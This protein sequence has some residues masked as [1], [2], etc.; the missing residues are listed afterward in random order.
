MSLSQST[1]VKLH[2]QLLGSPSGSPRAS[3]DPTV[4]FLHGLVMD[5][6][7]S[8]FFTMANTVSRS[9]RVLLYDLRGHGLSERPREGYG[10]DAHV[11]DLKALLDE[12]QGELKG[13]LEIAGP[14]ILVGNSFGGLLALNFAQRYPERVAGMILVDGQLNDQE[15]K[16]QMTRSLRLQG[17]E[18][19]QVIAENFKSW[20]GRNSQRKSNRLAQSASD[21]VGGTTL[22]DD[23]GASASMR[24]EDLRAI[25]TPTLAIYGVD[26]DII[27]TGRKLGRMLP[28]IQLEIFESCTHSVLWEKTDEVK[29]LILDGIGRFR[30]RDLK[31]ERGEARQWQDSFL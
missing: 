25:V 2:Y 30:R 17:A 28:N 5:N 26:S 4:V 23:L 27:A 3:D 19:D 15:W 9:S 31:H 20:R 16:N 21:L 8:W 10:I 22:V 1:P 18:R 24:D 12:L 29:A 11:A 7:S 13:D 6:L 14:V